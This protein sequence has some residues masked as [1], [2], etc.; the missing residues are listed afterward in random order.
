MKKLLIFA[1]LLCAKAVFAQKDTVGLNIPYI[2]STVAYER[3]FNAP[4]ATA[5]ILYA[6][7]GI[8]LA[9]THPY[10]GG[11]TQLTLNDPNLSRVLGRA[12][13]KYGETN[14]ILWN[15]NYWEVIINF[16]IQIDCKDNKYRVRIYNIQ[17]QVGTINI[18][19]EY[20]MQSFI[21]GK[22]Y[23]YNNTGGSMKTDELKQR[24]QALNAV[25]DSVMT[26]INKGITEDNSF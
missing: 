3:V 1:F 5:N 7:A 9:E 11:T 13:Y 22:S 25:V 23:P 20:M 19:I 17:N 2:N 21:N 24:F 26:D 4:N 8:W 14:K 12:T 18:P 15:D 6:N 16:T 10:G